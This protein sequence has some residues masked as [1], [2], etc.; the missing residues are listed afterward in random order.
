MFLHTCHTIDSIFSGEEYGEI[1]LWPVENFTYSTIYGH[2]YTAVIP[3]RK[4]PCL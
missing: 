4:F 1:L 2:T 3:S